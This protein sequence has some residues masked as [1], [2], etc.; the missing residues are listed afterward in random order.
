MISLTKAIATLDALRQHKLTPAWIK[1]QL[2]PILQ[3]LKAEEAI[4]RSCARCSSAGER[5]G[6]YRSAR[7]AT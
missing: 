2:A 4:K 1:D 6:S 7:S 5:W 3:G